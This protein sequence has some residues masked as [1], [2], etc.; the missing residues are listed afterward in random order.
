MIKRES[1]IKYFQREAEATITYLTER[2]KNEELQDQLKCA[3]LKAA[4]RAHESEVAANEA[5]RVAYEAQAAWYHSKLS[6]QDK[7]YS[8]P[9]PLSYSPQWQHLE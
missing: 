4:I 1:N 8:V 2:K 3:A 9:P 7:I 5:K 6:N